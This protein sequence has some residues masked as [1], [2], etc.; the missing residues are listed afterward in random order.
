MSRPITRL[1]FAILIVAAFGCRG[2][3]GG[4]TSVEQAATGQRTAAQAEPERPATERAPSPE[5]ERSTSTPASDATRPAGDREQRAIALANALFG[6]IARKNTKELEQLLRP[7]VWYLSYS[8][9]GSEQ[10]GDPCG[11]DGDKVERTA[12]DG[13]GVDW[14]AS[15]LIQAYPLELFVKDWKV[16]PSEWGAHFKPSQFRPGPKLALGAYRAGFDSMHERGVVVELELAGWD[17]QRVY[18]IY[19]CWIGVDDRSDAITGFACEWHI[20]G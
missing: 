13:P 2:K 17:E 11:G 19:S 1:C 9:G 15:C 18:V 10:S 20:P 5:A 6:A 3:V 14:I 8:R 7:P 12:T 16:N 4:G